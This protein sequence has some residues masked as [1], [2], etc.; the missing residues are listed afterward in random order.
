MDA[1]LFQ[2][3]MDPTHLMY[4]CRMLK[5]KV[6]SEDLL[7]RYAQVKRLVD[8]IDGHLT[9]GDLA[10]IVVSVGDNPEIATELL[11]ES[12]DKVIEDAVIAKELH[13]TKTMDATELE[14][15]QVSGATGQAVEK[16]TPEEENAMLWSPGMPVNV[17]YKDEITPGR[18]VGVSRPSEVGKQVGAAVK[19]TVEFE[20]GET[21]SF[22]EKEVEAV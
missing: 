16:P 9:A 12:D 19:L 21:E 2:E 8:R 11:E 10:M 22:D 1:E 18:I 6:L 3:K 15:D 17:L 5:V 7:E 20:G 13:L 14:E 4:L